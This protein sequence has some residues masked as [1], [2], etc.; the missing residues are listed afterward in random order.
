MP[1]SFAF[2]FTSSSPIKQ[3]TS[4][5]N[6]PAAVLLIPDAAIVVSVM[7]GSPRRIASF[8]FSTAPSVIVRVSL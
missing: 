7:I 2:T 6:F 1:L 4:I 5:P 8:A 3:C